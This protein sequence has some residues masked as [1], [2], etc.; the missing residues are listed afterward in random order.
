M[1]LRS[2]GGRFAAATFTAGFISGKPF[3]YAGP[4]NLPLGAELRAP[5]KV[6]APCLRLQRKAP[7]HPDISLAIRFNLRFLI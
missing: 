1:Y 2:V 7:G 5:K 3:W 6:H 4:P